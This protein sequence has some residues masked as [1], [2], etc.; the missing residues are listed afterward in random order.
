MIVPRA[1]NARGLAEHGWLTSHHSFSFGDYYDAQEMGFGDLRV[2]NEDVIQGGGGFPAHPHRNM[3]ILTYVLSGAL[4][5]EDNMGNGSV[6]QAGD[7][8]RMTAG[9]GVVH[10]ESNASAVTPV[11]LFQIWVLPD[12]EGHP[13]E[14]EQQTPP[15]AGRAG[16]FQMLASGDRA[17]EGL[18]WHQD[19]QLLTAEL[20]AGA[21]L[22]YPLRHGR[23]QY[24]QVAHGDLTINAQSRLKTGDG[25]RIT[26]ES[27]L[28]LSAEQ[29]TT[30]LLFDLRAAP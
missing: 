13:P 20:K 8:Q 30:I 28:I 10:S 21:E 26:R 24:L 3:E 4:R 6:I 17:D 16:R 29:D 9:T 1:T 14:Y 15:R 5:H 27:R 23:M 22:D 19:A 18:H 11:H 7:V 25:C 2:I 12:R